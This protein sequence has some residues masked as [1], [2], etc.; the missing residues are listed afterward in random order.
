MIQD[1]EMALDLLEQIGIKPIQKNIE[2]LRELEGATGRGHNFLMLDDIKANIEDHHD[3]RIIIEDDKIFLRHIWEDEKII[4]DCLDNMLKTKP[5]E[6][7]LPTKPTEGNLIPT[8]TQWEAVENAFKHKISI[9]QGLPGTGKSSL[10]RYL[11]QAIDEHPGFADSPSKFVLAAP[12][13][14]A[15][16]RLEQATGRSACTIHRLLG[17]TP[18][19][20]FLHSGSYPLIENFIIIDEASMIDINL[21]SNL[22]K[23]VARHSHIIFVGD[24]MQLPP[25]GAGRFFEDIINLDNMPKIMLTEIFRQAGK[26]LIIKNAHRL[27][28]GKVMFKD[29]SG[30]SDEVNDDFIFS[31]IRSHNIPDIVTS[32]VA[33]RLPE[34]K[35]LD[36]FEEIMVITPMKKGKC[37]TEAL[38]DKLQK[39]L[40]DGAPPIGYRNF[41]IGDRVIQTKN[42]YEVDIMNG[43]MGIIED[44]NYENNL[45]FINFK[46]KSVWI[47]IKKLKSFELGYAITVHKSQGSQAPAVVFVADNSARR[48]I[49]KRLINT[50]ITRAE[51]L[52][53]MVGQWDN[54]NKAIEMNHDIPLNSNIKNN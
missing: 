29:S 47:D 5:K 27:V 25:V 16:R 2:L 41:T 26:S 23:S 1:R 46:H 40:N 37:G 18:G 15:A 33:E 50:G 36:P 3:H 20:G 45:I 9:I 49:T 34:A 10:V 44:V 48:M 51:F 28:N 6:I 43:E 4:I 21:A 12:T 53:H 52:C 54:M 39:A 19:V 38:N 32:I 42:D 17:F 30:C 24:A 7:E 8:D 22:L 13:G 11:L 14:K 35:G 31:D